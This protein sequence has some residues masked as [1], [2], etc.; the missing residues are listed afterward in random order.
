MLPP[1]IAYLSQMM[2]CSVLV[3]LADVTHRCAWVELNTAHR[4]LNAF[5]HGQQPLCA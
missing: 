5:L 4:A 2:L 3:M 1:G